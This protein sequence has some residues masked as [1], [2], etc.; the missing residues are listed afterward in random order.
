MVHSTDDLVAALRLCAEYDGNVTRAARETGLPRNTL[1][2]RLSVA[3]ERGLHLSDGARAVTA[4]A[5]LNPV[6]AKGGWVH[7]YDSDGKK[8]GTTRWS[9]TDPQWDIGDI[10]SQIEAVMSDLPRAELIAPPE[11]VLSDLLTV[12]PIADA[13][14]GMLAWGRETG[15]QYDTRIA[16]ARLCDWMTRAV[17]A[18]PASE[19]A[20]ILDVGDLT[21][22]DDQSNA[23][24]RSKHVLDVDSRHVR[25]I[26]ETIAAMKFAVE[27]ALQKHRHVVVRIL[28]GNH[29]P[30]AHLPVTVA[31]RERYGDNSR[32]TVVTDPNEF[33]VHE[34]GKVM[35]A[36]HHGDKAKATRLVGMFADT[37]AQVWGRTQHRYLFTGHLHHHKSEDIFGMTWEQSRAVTARDAYAVAHSYTARAQLQAITFHREH[38]EIQRAKVG[39]L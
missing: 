5:Q 1:R 12:Y 26:W 17:S 30:H 23:T 18:A 20:I 33:F 14:I 31:I 13:H 8:T 19:T 2:N 11:H 10:M 4:A 24:P 22:A 21:H 29:N 37:H 25:T 35:I 7:N 39:P 15:E 9:A 38:G 6:E 32:V 28:P 16:T 36:A 3:K 27:L 34:F